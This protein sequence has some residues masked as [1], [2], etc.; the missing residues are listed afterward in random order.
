MKLT[1]ETMDMSEYLV[2]SEIIDFEDPDI[3]KI[4]LSLSKDIEDEI[5]V[6]RIVY[7]FVR[8]NI[9]H[10]ADIGNDK[11]IC[12]AFENR[13][14]QNRRFCAFEISDFDAP[15]T[16][17]SRAPKNQRFFERF[18]NAPKFLEF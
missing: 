3:Q 6:I 18:S 5:Q 1:P 9:F 16:S 15:N 4:A 7:E 2:S 14:L 8:D 17:Y 11:I 13:S 12:K 10:S